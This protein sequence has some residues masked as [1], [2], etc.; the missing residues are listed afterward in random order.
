MKVMY[1]SNETD[2]FTSFDT[3]LINTIPYKYFTNTKALD[4]AYLKGLQ[5]QIVKKDSTYNFDD[6][7][8][9][10]NQQDSIP[11]VPEKKEDFKYLLQNIELKE[12][13]IN[14]Y[15]ADFDN[16]TRLQNISFAIPYVAWDQEN[17]SKAD[18]TLNFE[19][20]GSL[21][22]AFNA[23]P[24]TLN[25]EG[26][27]VL[28]KIDLSSFI[29]HLSS[30]TNI[31]SLAGSLN[32]HIN[33][34]GNMDKLE[35]MI[36]TGDTDVLNFSMTDQSDTTFYAAQRMYAEYGEIKAL[37]QAVN[38]KNV[39]VEQPFIEFQLDSVS[40]NWF[41]IFNMDAE[42]PI[43]QEATENA[44][45]SDSSTFYYAINN[46]KVT[47]GVMDYTDNL[48]GQP[49]HCHLSDIKMDT[50]SITSNSQWVDVT[51]DMLLN[52]EEL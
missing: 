38:I 17:D 3:L 16:T 20:G 14:L 22:A 7:V 31:N 8:R 24:K 46:L 13:A 34:S 1:E 15:E 10:F 5:V 30:Y 37:K 41:R 45:V 25:F 50:D 35:D 51:S 52:I 23:N 18:M 44:Q 43:E 49:F 32:A 9:F 48:T 12:A 36:L 6:L 19:R 11:E 29:K 4:Q 21:Q 39:L 2:V 26:Q 33:L 40:N 28:N 27:F 42:S 47:G